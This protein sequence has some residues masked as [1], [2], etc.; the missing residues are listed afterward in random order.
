MLFPSKSIKVAME[1]M[2]VNS[3]GSEFH[4][5]KFLI[6]YTNLMS[7]QTLVMT[8]CTNI[9]YYST[10]NYT[11]LADG[12]WQVIILSYTIHVPS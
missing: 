7:T 3:D 2:G 12:K 5:N 9:Q 11:T 10:I 8:N 6:I 4:F 1:A